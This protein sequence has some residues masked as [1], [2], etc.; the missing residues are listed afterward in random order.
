LEK[1]L[2]YHLEYF[3]I[4]DEGVEMKYA[5]K[6]FKIW[7]TFAEKDDWESFGYYFTGLPGYFDKDWIQVV[8]AAFK[9]QDV[10]KYAL[11]SEG[12]TI[13]AGEQPQP[14]EFL[15]FLDQNTK[16]IWRATNFKGKVPEQIHKDGRIWALYGQKLFVVNPDNKKQIL[17]YYES[18]AMSIHSLPDVIRE[19]PVEVDQIWP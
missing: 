15:I 10:S 16:G 6:F 17:V 3:E 2:A 14:Q 9:E 7:E 8:A 13:F 5:K 4:Q 1:D 18:K 12:G 19:M 11:Y